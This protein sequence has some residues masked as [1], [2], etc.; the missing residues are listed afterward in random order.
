[1]K[2]KPPHS[3]STDTDADLPSASASV[4]SPSATFDPWAAAAAKHKDA[5]PQS[6]ERSSPQALDSAVEK[7]ESSAQPSPQPSSK[8]PVDTEHKSG[9]RDRSDTRAKPAYKERSASSDRA[10]R[11]M[12][13]RGAKPSGK[14]S[15]DGKW[16]FEKKSDKSPY[17]SSTKPI[18]LHPRNPHS[19]R[20]DMTLLVEVL[21]DLA[22]FL[23]LNPSGE[24]T[25]DF[26]NNAAVLC[27]NTALLQHYYKV[28]DWSI[29]KGYLCPPIPGRADYIHYL[30]DLLAEHDV[31]KHSTN[32]PPRI[33]D[34]GT[35]AN[36]IYPIIGTHAY[37]WQFT[38]T[39]TDGTAVRNAHAIVEANPS[40]SKTEILMQ[41]N[42]EFLF[43]NMIRSGDYF[44]ATMCNP[45]FFSSQ[46]E[47]ENQAARKW[48]NLKG[49]KGSV[50][51]NFG[52]KSNELWCE[53]GELA[54]LKRMMRESVNYADQVGWFTSLVS[55]GDH[56]PLFKKVLQQQGAK[57]IEITPM[58]QGQKVSRFIAWRY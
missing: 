45:P 33:L 30:A 35:G 10:A 9:V 53:G 46:R 47:A 29:P 3:A 15:A 48:K 1:M 17:A 16:V 50:T 51:R 32:E 28:E 36:L 22:D 5:D 26:S 49:E 7:T 23:Q 37:G 41:R 14:R 34:I 27:L 56:L 11:S 25:I 18:G 2:S 43:K 42:S 38:G 57:Q 19:G 52:G 21:P 24:Q 44:E 8:P 40:L 13:E 4:E 58:A 31:S 54:F 12:G 55:D 6:D 39:E 20:Y